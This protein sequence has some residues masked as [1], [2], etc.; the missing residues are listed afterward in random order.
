MNPDHTAVQKCAGSEE[1]FFEAHRILYYSTLGWRVI[2]KKKKKE[3]T[4]HRAAEMFWNFFVPKPVA[5]SVGTPLYSTVT[6]KLTDLPLL[7]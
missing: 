2:K 3:K 4:T 6:Y 1:D 5:E 7:R